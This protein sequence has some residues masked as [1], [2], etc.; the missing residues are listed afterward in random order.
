MDK[1][2]IFQPFLL[3]SEL[4]T[5]TYTKR[6]KL[7]IFA[8]F[9]LKETKQVKVENLEPQVLQLLK[10]WYVNLFASIC[11]YLFVTEQDHLNQCSVQCGLKRYQ[12]K[13][14]LMVF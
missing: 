4:L 5:D 10:T 7:N 9:T 12:K 6:T 11:L 2:T 13:H 14:Y 1:I 8:S 3:F